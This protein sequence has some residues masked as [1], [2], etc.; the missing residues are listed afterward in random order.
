MGRKV[1]ASCL[2]QAGLA[3]CLKTRFCSAMLSALAALFT[4]AFLA[5]TLLPVQSEAMLAAM[6]AAKASPHAALLAVASLGNTLGAAVNWLIGR[7]A[8][9]FADRAWFPVRAESLDR[10]KR[11]YG[12]FG[13]WSLLASWAP[14][15]G[16]PLTLAAGLLG[17]PFWRFML[18][19]GFVKTARYAVVAYAALQAFSG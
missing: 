8:E 16:D 17:E 2:P 14:F 15:I 18:I 7:K 11:W 5:A 19:V 12:R 3:S 10:A 6:I 9:T 13:R 4:A 1:K